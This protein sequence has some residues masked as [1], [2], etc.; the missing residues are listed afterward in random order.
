MTDDDF[1]LRLDFLD[2]EASAESS[3]KLSPRIG[4]DEMNLA[5]FPFALLSD[6][7]PEGVDTIQ[8]EDAVEGKDGLLVKRSW[9]VTGG[10]KFGLPLAADEQVYVVLMELTKEHGFD[11]RTIPMTRYD[12]IKRLGWPN[13]GESY[14][15]LREAL[16]RLLGV[17][18]TARRAFWDKAKQRYVD[19]G[20]HII[21]DYALYDE[22]PGRK[23]H[24]QQDPLPLSFISWSQVI[25]RSFQA[26]NIKQLDTA[27][28]FSL[29]SSLSRRLYRYLDK[30][31][32][33]GKGQYRIGVRKLAFEK[34]GMSRNYY[35]SNIKQELQRAHHELIQNGFLQDVEYER[36]GSGAEEIVVY[37]F[38]QRKFLV[39]HTPQET[40]VA[41]ELCEQLLEQGVTPAV[42]RQL[43]RDFGDEVRIQL[44][45]LSHRAPQDPAAV[46]VE[47]IKGRWEPPASYL[48]AR[49]E[50]KRRQLQQQKQTL[51]AK[52]KAQE[53]AR[54]ELTRATTEA[55]MNKLPERD[56]AR[57]TAEATA[58][59]NDKSPAVA[60]RPQSRAFSAIL[61]EELTALL[62]GEFP[63]DFE[64]TRVQLVREARIDLND[65]L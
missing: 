64:R 12:L 62:L 54:I 19:V 29:R 4:R 16:D 22:A 30:K 40:D 56:R 18:I 37:Y 43:V 35:L 13:K 53:E 42:S 5:E 55:L 1:E 65:D 23:R 2:Q 8:F 49:A 24:N 6:R 27:F 48:K 14:R 31:R 28:Y 17:T 9:T 45:Y 58:R 39:A 20:F 61:N 63:E 41:Q 15:R 11:Q 26:G 32:Y 3:E 57:I 36:G 44:Q 51:Q 46:L 21:D 59:V 60:R 34:L 10:E 25:F 52:L 38:T 7:A 47:A 33:D 50:E